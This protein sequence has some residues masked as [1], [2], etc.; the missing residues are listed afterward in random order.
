MLLFSFKMLYIH[1]IK[2]GRKGQTLREI[3]YFFGKSH[4]QQ[5]ETTDYNTFTGS[6]KTDFDVAIIDHNGTGFNVPTPNISR[7]YSRATVTV[8]VPG[9]FLCDRLSLKT[10]YL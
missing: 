7:Q 6:Y 1:N 8:G 2:D 4:F 9:A 3:C 10:G 5:V